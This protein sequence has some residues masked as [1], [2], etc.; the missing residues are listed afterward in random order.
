MKCQRCGSEAFFQEG[1]KLVDAVGSDAVVQLSLKG[2]CERLTAW[3]CGCCAEMLRM[4][5]WKCG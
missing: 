1:H 2:K 5:G 4:L 3:V